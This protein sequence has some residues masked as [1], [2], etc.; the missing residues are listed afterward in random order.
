MTETR[1]EVL[2]AGLDDATAL[3]VVR[4]LEPMGVRFQRAPWWA[5]VAGVA[6][7]N[8]FEVVI[9][10]LPD[11]ISTLASMIREVRTSTSR[12]RQAALIVV[13]QQE[14]VDE[15][16]GLVGCGVNRVVTADRIESELPGAVGHLLDIA[17][18]FRF[19]R[20]IRVAAEGTGALADAREYIVEN[21][22]TSGMLLHGVPG[23]ALGAMVD[24][25]IPIA[26]DQE[27]IQGR[28]RVVWTAPSG[29]G[30][31]QRIG[32]RFETLSEDDRWRLDRVL[33]ALTN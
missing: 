10:N 29:R 18:R 30:P 17:P 19:G 13:A 33:A 14:R 11:D 15:A 4:E 27:P 28:A 22:S 6:T 9:V 32:A 2:L 24:F 8:R 20:S 7:G 26:S 21:I 16:R 1:P 5:A 23:I 3:R 31:E 12:S 25:A